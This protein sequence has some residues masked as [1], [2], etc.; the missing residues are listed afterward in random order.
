VGPIDTLLIEEDLIQEGNIVV[1]GHGVLIVDGATLR[2][3]A[4]YGSR[5]MGTPLCATVDICTS[6]NPT[7]GSTPSG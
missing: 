5:I 4:S 1:F 7:S 6:T 2:S 3:P